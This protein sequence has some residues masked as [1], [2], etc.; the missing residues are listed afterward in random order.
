MGEEKQ[1]IRK[2]PSEKKC[3][4]IIGSVFFSTYTIWRIVKIT[5]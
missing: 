4:E 5:N 2:K 3:S 1:N